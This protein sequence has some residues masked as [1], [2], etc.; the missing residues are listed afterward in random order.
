MGKTVLICVGC[1]LVLSLFPQGILA[2]QGVKILSY[3][4]Q[5][6]TLISASLDQLKASPSTFTSIDPNFKD[7]GPTRFTGTSLENFLSS[8]N[9]SFKEGVTIVG[10]DQYIGYIPY[11]ILVKD[12][13]FLTWE[14]NEKAIG[15]MKGGPL[16]M[17]YPGE[18]KVH[19]S[20]YVWYVDAII[21]GKPLNPF[22]E[23]SFQGNIKKIRAK[24]L[25]SESER[26][27]K[28]LF[29]MP[30]GCRHD[31]KLKNN[32][33]VIKA[34]DLNKLIDQTFGTSPQKVTLI[35][36]AGSSILIT[37]QALA[38]PI[39]V[40]LSCD[41]NPIHP[42][43]GGPFSVIFPVERHRSMAGLVP[44]SGALFFLNKIIVE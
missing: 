40:T 29:S 14:L 32:E 44:E 24:D 4:D 19:G 15:I 27:D 12:Q 7:D 25:L 1:L 37:K 35:P 34:I 38:F 10:M 33:V 39:F 26:L 13:A 9:I 30:A 36:S 16:K 41:G 3:P 17:I 21:A 43:F 8:L 18:A 42:A 20:C 6:Q 28:K 23:V 2:S 22:F 31:M 11:R 5:G